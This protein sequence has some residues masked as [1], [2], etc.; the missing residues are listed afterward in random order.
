M[1]NVK[2]R[3]ISDGMGSPDSIGMHLSDWL[4]ESAASAS[5]FASSPGLGP[6]LC[7]NLD[8]NRLCHPTIDS[9]PATFVSD[10]I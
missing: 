5:S 2:G 10:T 7:S 3:G 6:C 1:R 8:D 4:R 9:A